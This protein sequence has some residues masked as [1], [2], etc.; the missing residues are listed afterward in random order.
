MAVFRVGDRARVLSV[1][2]AGTEQSSPVGVTPG[3][4]GRLGIDASGA[5][6]TGSVFWTQGAAP[7]RASPTEESMTSLP[8]GV[9][10]QVVP[11]AHGRTAIS[12][13]VDGEF[14]AWVHVKGAGTQGWVWG[15][16]L[17]T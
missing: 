14:G 17:R 15:P 12:A 5:Y 7:L 4:H 2:D 9:K 16:T 3:A 6:P 13:E 10:L 11:D 1:E 8:A